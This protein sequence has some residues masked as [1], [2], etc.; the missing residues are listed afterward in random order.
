MSHVVKEL[1]TDASGDQDQQIIYCKCQ[2]IKD[3][4]M[5]GCDNYNCKFK[6][7]HKTCVK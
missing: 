1:W 7:L 4:P 5:I 6:W 2:Q 3:D